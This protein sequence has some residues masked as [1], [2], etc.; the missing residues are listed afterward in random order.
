[1]S[2]QLPEGFE[3]APDN[4]LSGIPEGFEFVQE[5][6]SIPEGFELVDETTIEQPLIAGNLQQ[7]PLNEQISTNSMIDET[8]SSE[9]VIEKTPEQKTMFELMSDKALNVG[10]GFGERSNQLVGNLLGFAGT[11]TKAA[12]FGI[13]EI[14]YTLIGDSEKAEAFKEK[15]KA[16]RVEEGKSADELADSFRK[17]KFY[18]YKEGVST[19]D[20][21]SSYKE[22][23]LLNVDLLGKVA[24]FGVEQGIKSIPDMVA[25]TYALPAYVMSRSE[26][27]GGERAKNKGKK[28]T[29]MIDVLEAVPA[30]V[31]SIAFDKLGLK[32]MT[33][34]FKKKAG[35]EIVKAGFR[36]AAARVAKEGLKAVAGETV[37]EYVQEGIIE[38]VGEK[39]GTQAE[40]TL[41]ESFE[42]GAFGALAGGLMGGPMGATGG[43]AAELSRKGEAK[44]AVVTEDVATPEP[45]PEGF[46]LDDTVE[47][48]KVPEPLP[49]PEIE[50]DFTPEEKV[51]EVIPEEN[52]ETERVAI[53]ESKI[54]K[55]EEITV[56]GV[57]FDKKGNK[58]LSNNQKE[59]IVRIYN[60]S[61]RA[62]NGGNVGIAKSGDSS[63]NVTRSDSG[64]KLMSKIDSSGNTDKSGALLVVLKGGYPKDYGFVKDSIIE[65]IDNIDKM[66]N[67]FVENGEYFQQTSSGDRFYFNENTGKIYK[68]LPYKAIKIEKS[69]SSKMGMETP[70]IKDSGYYKGIVDGGKKKPVKAF[71]GTV[72]QFKE[73]DEGKIGTSTDSG[74]YGKG[75]Y[76]ANDVKVAKRYAKK[77]GRV[78]EVELDL[79][80]PY[81]INSKADIPKIDVPSETMEDLAKSDVNYS[82]AF[83]EHLIDKGHDGVIDNMNPK[84]K[85]YVVFDKKNVKI[86]RSK[87]KV[88][89]E[90][91]FEGETKK[92][93]SASKAIES[94]KLNATGAD[95]PGTKYQMTYSAMGFPERPSN[96]MV[97]IGDKEIKLKPEDNPTRREGIQAQV[98]SIIGPRLYNSK[99]KGKST[100]GTYD[101]QNSEVRTKD[102]HAVEVLS[103]EMA[104][105]MDFHH[106]M[107]K[108]FTNAYEGDFASLGEVSDLSYTTKK[109]LQAT[110]GFA[111]YVRL[112]LTQYDKA[113]ELAPNFTERFEAVLSRDKSM[114][115]KMKL[116]QADMHRWLNQGDLARLAAVTSGNQY[117]A[118]ERMTRFLNRR[119]TSLQRQK[120][121]DHIHAAKVITADVKGQLGD[122]TTDPYKQLQLLNGLDGIFEQSVKH[123]APKFD[124]K[125]N[126]TFTGPSI[127]DV[128]GKSLKHSVGRLREQEQ[129]FIARR[130]TETTKQDRENLIT[131][132]MIREGLKLGKKHPYFKEAFKDYQEYRENLM[133]FYVSTGY[134]DAKAAKKML[135]RNRNYVPF[136]RVTEGV[137]E[138]GKGGGAGFQ[139]LKGGTQN[140]RHVYDNIL[141][142]DSK[143][144]QGALKAKALR[145][146]YSE[147]LKSQEGSKWFTE[148]DTDTKPVQVMLDQM[149]QKTKKMSEELGLETEFGIKE[150]MESYFKEHPEE[151]M[152]WNFGNK[153]STAETMVDSF[154]DEDTGERVWVEFNKEN[155]LLPD[156][157]EALGGF[158]LPKGIAGTALSVAMKVKQFQT[159]TIT[160]MA[161]F[162]GPNIVRDQQQAY[163]LSGGKYN[164]LIDPIKGLT[165]YIKSAVGKGHLFEEMKAQGGPG[166]GRV[167]TFLEAD[168]GFSDTK[169]YKA[170]KPFYHP[171]QIAK[172]VLDVYVNI[173]DSAE[174]ATR[175]GFYSRMKSE[176]K[177]PREAAFMSREISTDFAK[178]GSYAAF[179]G[180]QRTVPFF[181]A[182]VQSVDR[183]LRGMFERNGKIR[184]S[185]FFKN[186]NGEQE[187]TAFKAKMVAIG[188]LYVSIHMS[189]ALLGSDEEKYKEL[190]P[191]QKAR[192]FH[193]FI[194][195]EHYTIPKPHGLVT[196]LGSFAEGMTDLLMGQESKTV[197]NDIIF[198][199]TYHLGAD[200]IPGILTPISD[201]YL[202]TTFT[203][204]PIVGRGAEPRS[205]QYQ[206]SDRTPQLY[207]RI[208]KGLG[209]SPDRARH[210]IKGYTGYIEE[211]IAENTEEYLWDYEAWGE[212]PN[213]RSYG[214]MI[215]KQF[216]PKKIP[217]RTKYTSGY[218]DLKE[219]AETAKANFSFGISE[220]HKDKK[221]IKEV[222]RRKEEL[223]F[224]G[225][226]KLFKKVDTALKSMKQGVSNITYNKNLT[227]EEKTEKIE[228][229]YA[230]KNKLL[231][232]V[233]FSI[234]K[235]LN[236]LEKK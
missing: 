139:Q 174:M 167:N 204:A 35:K 151:L 62:L 110:E 54:I 43:V 49:D 145:D 179:V 79:K 131:P 103:H 150:D 142:Q 107:K 219:R 58:V 36:Y 216:N 182:Y 155:E 171:A 229:L 1:M 148:I 19:E 104:H 87:T 69:A 154:I 76:F 2:D 102:Y 189:L 4:N 135:E 170:K 197:G 50:E 132:D 73:F 59:T 143:H 161:Q 227:G 27:M 208:G 122:A 172:D 177:S 183:D 41:A 48:E 40:M 115:R 200:A 61:I 169:Q 9:G 10:A 134:L 187:Y 114:N 188:M 21:K 24:E 120:Y 101:I 193:Y 42:R 130:A 89:I 96:D 90:K 93:T 95:K 156:M 212:R 105:F 45:I 82:K 185:N 22:G 29:E 180:L 81:T 236:E 223:T 221:T 106:K 141:M 67:H 144:L 192:F 52:V 166:G 55:D 163:F 228:N 72:K 123:G 32:W 18:D 224:I 184:M 157:L 181:G 140:I 146:M 225:L 133:D 31:G 213:K 100:L 194:D 178:H 199:L 60:E 97:S 128:W 92:P 75:F 30:T 111:E 220:A 215:T 205:A 153:P 217:F 164:P 85:Q 118:K 127:E 44:E 94:T 15:W 33:A 126:I 5:S 39:W 165:E 159:L 234:T 99:V 198:A 53:P 201:L 108:Q 231:K 57:D 121:I 214:D 125:G 28:E 138:S 210:F 78:L 202:N 222:T 71:H 23:G 74:M 83:T 84:E 218:Y 116:L 195:G 175:I 63:Y 7:E 98:E 207:K 64:V 16:K 34:A 20:I 51:S 186:P 86:I 17:T 196:L 88:D 160:S 176:G 37:T 25:M 26:E 152:F 65:N 235:T 209:V 13:D 56:D 147:G 173:M 47:A 206:Y 137:I 113:V 109:G 6:S 91:E 8:L 211:I 124:S 80:N 136:H 190:T 168:F 70:K 112:W 191:D 149:L 226:D 12:K 232:D 77:D 119:P 203:G 117:S 68:H 11:Q 38:Y 46:V 230:Q 66:K 14:A 3:L 158:A 129:Y 162:A 233:Y